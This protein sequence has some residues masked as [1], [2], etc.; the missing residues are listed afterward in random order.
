[1]LLAVVV[2][3]LWVVATTPKVP[4]ISGRDVTMGR[5][6]I[7]ATPSQAGSAATPSYAPA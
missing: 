6:M 2:P 7:R 3:S 5:R 1:M 4:T